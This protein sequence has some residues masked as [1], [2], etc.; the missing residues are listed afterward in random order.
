MGG[1]VPLFT[2]HDMDKAGFEIAQR[3]TTIS[4]YARENDLVKY[5]FQ[6]EINVTDLG[7]RLTDVEEYGLKSERCR[8]RGDFPWDTIATPEEQAFLRQSPRRAECVH[9]AAVHRMA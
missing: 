8:F 5:E 2:A 4:D 1:G 9:G 6:N 3:F 7:L